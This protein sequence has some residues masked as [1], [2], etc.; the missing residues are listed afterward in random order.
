MN[1]VVHSSLKFSKK[2][3]GYKE[4]WIKII[5]Y[6]KGVISGLAGSPLGIIFDS[7]GSKKIDIICIYCGD[8]W[9]Q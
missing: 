8:R 3:D 7:S 1:R 9:S 5:L 6:G 4:A 2:N